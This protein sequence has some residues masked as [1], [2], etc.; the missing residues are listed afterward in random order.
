MTMEYKNIKLGPL[1][2]SIF[3]LPAGYEKAAMPI[4]SPK[5]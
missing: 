2:D 5:E 4:V 1:D 3:E